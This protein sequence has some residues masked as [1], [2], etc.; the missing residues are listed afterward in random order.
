MKFGLKNVTFADYEYLKERE[1]SYPDLCRSFD[2]FSGLRRAELTNSETDLDKILNLFRK[3][4]KK[5]RK[6]RSALITE[7]TAQ[8]AT[9]LLFKEKVKELPLNV[10]IFSTIETTEKWLQNK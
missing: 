9:T 4:L 1:F 2:I 7:N 3:N 6:R 10:K 8:V 5:I